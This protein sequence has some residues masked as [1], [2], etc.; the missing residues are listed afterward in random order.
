MHLAS[1]EATEHEIHVL[2]HQQLDVLRIEME[3]TPG[4][5]GR[6]YPIDQF[7]HRVCQLRF[8]HDRRLERLTKSCKYL[9]SLGKIFLVGQNWPQCFSA[10]KPAV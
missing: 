9:K 6:P 3:S 4:S 7:E 1:F 10:R 2:A 8:R 5:A